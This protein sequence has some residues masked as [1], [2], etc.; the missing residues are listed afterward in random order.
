MNQEQ[1]LAQRDELAREFHLGE[2]AMYRTPWIPERSVLY[3]RV[4][5]IV[6]LA[7]LVLVPSLNG[8]PDGFIILLPLGGIF[9]FIFLADDTSVY[10][11]WNGLVCLKRSG[12]QVAQWEDIRT[13]GIS[14]GYGGRGLRVL[15]A[16]LNDGIT[17]RF[18]ATSS[19]GSASLEDIEE[20]IRGNMAL[21]RDL[22][23]K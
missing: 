4:I 9:Y 12:G 18:P 3:A 2:L 8:Q 22:P 13:V 17:I 21:N 1:L 5:T 20:F 11:Y 14:G 19:P 7:L 15:R 16:T 23:D 10:V 6:V